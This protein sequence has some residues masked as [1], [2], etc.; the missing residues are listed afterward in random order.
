MRFVPF[1]ISNKITINLLENFSE[2][3]K[4]KTTKE[5]YAI[6]VSCLTTT[7][8]C[9]CEYSF[10]NQRL[11]NKKHIFFSRNC[12]KISIN[13]QFIITEQSLCV[14]WE[15]SK[16][17]R[18]S[19]NYSNFLRWAFCPS[20]LLGVVFCSIRCSCHLLIIAINLALKLIINRHL[21]GIFYIQWKID[22]G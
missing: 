16:C 7:Q 22:F 3:I 17:R 18:I 14:L 21:I 12:K 1:R 8:A 6:F 4:N 10:S 2:R 15:I 5:F 9:E 20:F 19:W 13:F 11:T